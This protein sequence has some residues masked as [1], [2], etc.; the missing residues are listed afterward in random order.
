MENKIIGYE[1]AGIT[2]IRKECRLESEF[3]VTTLR[4]SDSETLFTLIEKG[5]ILKNSGKLDNDSTAERSKA[6]WEIDQEI[7]RIRRL[8]WD[9]TPV[10]RFIETIDGKKKLGEKGFRF[11]VDARPIY[12]HSF[13]APVPQSE[14]EIS[15]ANRFNK[16]LFDSS[17]NLSKMGLGMLIII[18]SVSL[19]FIFINPI[20]FCSS[21][22]PL[23]C[24]TP[25]ALSIFSG[26]QAAVILAAG[27]Y[28]AIVFF[29][30]VPEVTIA[31]TDFKAL[32]RER[33]GSTGCETYVEFINNYK[34]AQSITRSI[35]YI[36]LAVLTGWFFLYVLFCVKGLPQLE[37]SRALTLPAGSRNIYA[38]S[39]NLGLTVI[40]DFLNNLV[41]LLIFLCFYIMY[42]PTAFR[43]EKPNII[44]ASFYGIGFF[45]IVL[46]IEIGVLSN[47]F[48]F[49]RFFDV[50]LIPEKS[51][52]M[53]T[54]LNNYLA[55][56][57][58]IS[59]ILGGF[60]MALFFGRLQSVF[61]KPPTWLIFVLIIYVCIQ[62]F[63]FILGGDAS[64]L[65][66][67][68]AALI[69]KTILF[70][71]IVYLFEKNR[72]LFYLIRMRKQSEKI[73]DEYDNFQRLVSPSVPPPS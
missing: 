32:N 71:F 10:K 68:S 29:D 24:G 18:F 9:A 26:F 15:Q 59:G 8:L 14:E 51:A 66:L 62:P 50:A 56:F 37:L 63:F 61:L 48:D 34:R 1:F 27:I 20:I 19:Y 22:D 49:L 2:F 70:T 43:N 33:P 58:A 4:S 69:S 16:W 39:T 53:L 17:N 52:E 55:H 72:F 41:S 21:S 38:I 31:E 6:D 46:F 54:K 40:I 23:I 44:K 13:P 35:K 30:E 67:M 42:L 47:Q 73:D 60:S 5:K 3:G 57:G 36:W 25:Y 64:G 28:Y 12:E 7:S 65:P 11:I 45:L